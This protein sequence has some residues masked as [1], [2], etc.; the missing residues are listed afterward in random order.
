MVSLGHNTY[1][2]E[3]IE[4]IGAEN[5]F[6]GEGGII[7]PSAEAV[8][9]GNPD[10]I[11]TNVYYGDGPEAEDAVEE[12]KKRPGFEH[13]R[14]VQNNRV[15]QIDADSSSRP[16]ARILTALKQMAQGLYEKH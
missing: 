8:I 1:L 6:A 14:A 12:I 5:I 9:S 16:S 10:V 11:F 3:M 15:Y 4:I 13:I 7:F 2:H